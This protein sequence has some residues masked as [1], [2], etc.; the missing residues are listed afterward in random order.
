MEQ[1]SKASNVLLFF[2]CE[3][4]HARLRLWKELDFDLHDRSPYTPWSSQPKTILL[5]L[6]WMIL[7]Y[8]SHT[9]WVDHGDSHVILLL[10]LVYAEFLKTEMG[11]LPKRTPGIKEMDEDR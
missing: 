8:S 4:S 10:N 5:V 2:F 1:G 6:H 7:Q 3:Q 9:K 11:E